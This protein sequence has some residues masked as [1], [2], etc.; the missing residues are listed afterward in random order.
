M[1]LDKR[2]PRAFVSYRHDVAGDPE[3][4]RAHRTWVQGFIEG[5]RRLGIEAIWDRDPRRG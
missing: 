5:L 1:S 4:N 3:A 2:K